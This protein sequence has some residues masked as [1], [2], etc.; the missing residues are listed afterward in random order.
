MCYEELVV[1]NYSRVGNMEGGNMYFE[2]EACSLCEK[3]FTCDEFMFVLTVYNSIFSIKSESF[4]EIKN[5]LSEI[6]SLKVTRFTEF[7]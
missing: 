6:Y 4:D 7:D 2:G 3:G 1:C 5:R